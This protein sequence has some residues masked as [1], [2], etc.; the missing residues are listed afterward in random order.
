MGQGRELISS[1][2][3]AISRPRT[4]L[5]R[6]ISPQLSRTLSS[7]PALLKPS[8]KAQNRV[9][10][11]YEFSMEPPETT[12]ALASGRSEQETGFATCLGQVP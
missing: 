3:I 2:S 6:S 8:I 1:I 5:Y 12:Q 9:T 4:I 7:L 10:L 11:G